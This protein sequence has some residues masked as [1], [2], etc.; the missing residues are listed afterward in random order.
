LDFNALL[1]YF[2]TIQTTSLEIMEIL[3]YND[4]ESMEVA[5]TRRYFERWLRATDRDILV[6]FIRCISG[7]SGIT[8]GLRLTVLSPILIQRLI[9]FRLP[10]NPGLYM[11]LE[12]PVA[13][14]MRHIFG[15][16]LPPAVIR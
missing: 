11:V 1:A 7:Q 16:N 8:P 12:E 5:R 13:L 9:C 14:S 2:S 10:L 15:P 6:K 4:D 3:Q